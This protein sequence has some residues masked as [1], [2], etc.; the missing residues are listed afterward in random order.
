MFFMK[1]GLMQSFFCKEHLQ[2]HIHNS[3]NSFFCQV[4]ASDKNQRMKSEK[5]K[6]F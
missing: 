1:L 4:F 2:K 3:F 6:L 5:Q